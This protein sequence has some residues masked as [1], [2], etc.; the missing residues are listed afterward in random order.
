ME[1]YT[2]LH[3]LFLLKWLMTTCKLCL[4]FPFLIVFVDWN[5]RDGPEFSQLEF[6]DGRVDA[7]LASLS[8]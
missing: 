3:R 8:K 6:L 4:Q 1:Q 5:C 7:S 2:N